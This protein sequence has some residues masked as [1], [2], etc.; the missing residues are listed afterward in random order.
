MK[1]ATRQLKIPPSSPI[2]A[3]FL[4]ILG[5]SVDGLVLSPGRVLST[6]QVSGARKR[7][8]CSV[9]PTT[10][11]ATHST[12][13]RHPL[14]HR[15]S[16]PPTVFVA[17]RALCFV[18]AQ[19]TLSLSMAAPKGPWGGSTDSNEGWFMDRGRSAQ[20]KKF[21]GG[22]DYL[23][24][25]GPSPLY[26]VQPDLPGVL[27]GVRTGHGPWGSGAQLHALIVRAGEP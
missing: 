10:T 9:Q 12:T 7:V 21:E 5:S 17:N 26:A 3:G 16:P 8:D 2:M 18:R 25:Q 15:Y 23:F 11:H 6:A 20:V 27:T 4:A 1:A 13:H 14:P 19:P 22:S 24:F